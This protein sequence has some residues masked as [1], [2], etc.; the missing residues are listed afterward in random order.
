MLS[1]AK[2]HSYRKQTDTF[3]IKKKKKLARFATVYIGRGLAQEYL[4]Y[5]GKFENKKVSI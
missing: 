4:G 5:R 1:I 3:P 2:F